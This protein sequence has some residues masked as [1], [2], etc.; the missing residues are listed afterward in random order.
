MQLKPSEA[1]EFTRPAPEAAH[2]L[3]PAGQFAIHETCHY[4]AGLLC[5]TL[6]GAPWLRRALRTPFARASMFAYKSHEE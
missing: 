3:R 2:R 1:F 4:V 6:L 5:A